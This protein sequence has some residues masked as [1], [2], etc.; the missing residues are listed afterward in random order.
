MAHE[1]THSLFDRRSGNQKKEIRFIRLREVLAICGKSRSS[2]Y[3]AITKGL[4]PKPVKLHGRSSAW[5]RSEMEQWAQERIDAR[6]KDVQGRARERSYSI[7]LGVQRPCVRGR[8]RRSGGAVIPLPL[9]AP[10]RLRNNG[11]NHGSETNEDRQEEQAPA[12]SCNSRRRGRDQ[13][14]G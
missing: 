2:V 1:T 6:E 4:F 11:E 5:V 13:T 3:D 8:E 10:R 9:A 14:D 12:R 7:L